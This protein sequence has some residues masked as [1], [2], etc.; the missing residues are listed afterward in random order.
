MVTR[1]YYMSIVYKVYRLN[2][3]QIRSIV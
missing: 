1:K 3:K 2:D